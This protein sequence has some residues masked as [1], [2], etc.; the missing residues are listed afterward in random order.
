MINVTGISYFSYRFVQ[1]QDSLTFKTDTIVEDIKRGGAALDRVMRKLYTDE[2]CRA[3]AQSVFLRLGGR[4]QEFEDI[5]QDSI[6]HLIMNVRRGKFKGD[7]TISTYLISICKNL[8]LN[9]SR[10]EVRHREILSALS[11][12]ES[13]SPKTP[14]DIMLFQERTEL[15]NTLI[16][17]TGEACRKVLSL[18]SLSYSMDE[19]A[20]QTGYKNAAIVRKKK[21]NCLQ[22]LIELVRKH[23]SQLEFFKR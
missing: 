12:E 19:I 1:K 21:H 2:K 5:F 22:R 13:T 11:T 14:E 7:S 23:R 9:K 20:K 8:W 3:Q 6:A 17:Q 4:E 16:E 18:W 15:F 10:K